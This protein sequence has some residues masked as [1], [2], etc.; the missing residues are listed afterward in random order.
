MTTTVRLEPF[1]AAIEVGDGE[2]VL[3]AVL[4]AGYYVHHACRAGRCGS[5][6]GRLTAGRLDQPLHSGFALGKDSQDRGAVLLCQARGGGGEAVVDI[7]DM[8]LDRDE[9][10]GG[11]ATWSAR[12]VGC[13]RP[14]ADLRIVALQALGEPRHWRAGAHVAFAV[15]GHGPAHRSYS[16]LDLPQRDGRFRVLLR[17]FPDGRFSGQIDALAQAGAVLAVR[18]PLGRFA[19]RR[20]YR[21]IVFV[22]GGT[23][24]G[25]IRAMVQ[26]LA[27]T[28]SRRQIH[29]LYGARDASDL[30]L[31]GELAALAASLPGL[32]LATAA[33][34]GD[35]ADVQG[36]VVELLGRVPDPAIRDAEAYLCG[37]EAMVAQLR[38]RLGAR[39]MQDR[40]IASDVFVASA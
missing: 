18:G 12:I 10:Q 38:E 3:D 11:L 23:G 25:P 2:T 7:A 9:F 31:R 20:G 29:L 26:D 5:C 21:P 33:E 6:A 16:L 8:Q 4:R 15:P 37:P 30:V 13:E 22:A 36:T 40:R 28:R 34:R 24:I 32:G 19:L 17:V 39:G 35:G 14:S 27:E 1:G